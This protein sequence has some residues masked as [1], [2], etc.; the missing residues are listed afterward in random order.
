MI[1]LNYLSMQL[2]FQ[3]WCISNWN[4]DFHEK[5]KQKKKHIF[6]D[7]AWWAYIWWFYI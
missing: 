2:S 6:E 1:S 7:I 5:T 3:C 4:M